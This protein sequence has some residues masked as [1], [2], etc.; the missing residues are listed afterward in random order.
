MFDKKLWKNATKPDEAAAMSL[1]CKRAGEFKIN[2]IFIYLGVVFSVV[3]FLW[4]LGA[5]S[6]ITATERSSPRLE[7]LMDL[8]FERRKSIENDC[9]LRK[10]EN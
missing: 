4:L 8:W 2:K 7:N 9:L 10:I 3:L 6:L 5:S 1:A